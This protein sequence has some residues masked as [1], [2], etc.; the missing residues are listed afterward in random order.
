M[1]NPASEY[2]DR[3]TCWLVANS[4]KPR[5]L[6]PTNPVGTVTELFAGVGGFRLGLSRAKWKTVFS[7]Q[8]EPATKSQL[9]SDVYVYR[10][11]SDGHSNVDIAKLLDEVEAGRTTIPASDLLVGGFP[12]QDYSVAKTLNAAAGLKGSKGVLWWE[13]LRLVRLKKPKLILLENVDRLLKSPAKQRGRDFAV[14]LASLADE[15]YLVEWR[16]VNAA[17]YGGNQR[18]KRVFIV[19]KSKRHF[20]INSK[21]N[22][23]DYLLKSGSLAQS[24]PVSS[25]GESR[26]PKSESPSSFTLNGDLSEISQKFGATA[27][28]SPFRNCGLIN[29]R[30]VSTFQVTAVS[31]SPGSLG[32]VLLDHEKVPSDFF[33][34]SAQ[35]KTWRY[36]KGAKRELRTHPGSGANYHYAEGSMAFPDLPENPSRTI[37]TGEGGSSPS[38]FKH[39]VRVNGR[40]FRRLTPVELERLNGFP[41]DWTRFTHTGEVSESKRAF[42]M[43]NALVVDIVE[44]IGRQLAKEFRATSAS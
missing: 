7:N 29:G 39:I 26:S 43:G 2:R 24:L 8:W 25:I 16:V 1:R 30:S 32:K 12:C 28:L 37:L 18:R 10:F 35:L 6:E 3:L 9:A 19:G 21:L 33:V 34:S 13:I 22:H 4:K 14:M 23:H 20:K 31:E 17:D 15:G 38:R 5:N 41:D 40:R 36:L 11:G 44:R 42:F 27:G